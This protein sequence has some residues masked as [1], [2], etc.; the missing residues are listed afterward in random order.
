MSNSAK[1]KERNSAFDDFVDDCF[2]ANDSICSLRRKEEKQILIDNLVPEIK[3]N[4][5]Y[6]EELAA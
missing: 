4:L 6:K 5:P 2:I 1:M 3:A